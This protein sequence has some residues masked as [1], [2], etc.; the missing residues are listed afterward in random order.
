MACYSNS[1]TFVHVDDV[2]TT[3]ETYPYASMACYSDS[4]TFVHV[5]DVRTTQKTPI[6]P[7]DLLQR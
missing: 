5:D 7:H 3:Q 2:R 6:R 4:F 1:F